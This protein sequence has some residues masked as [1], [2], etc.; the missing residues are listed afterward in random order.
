MKWTSNWNYP[1]PPF[2]MLANESSP[3]GERVDWSWHWTRVNF[4]IPHLTV[5]DGCR[6]ARWPW[7]R[8]FCSKG[9]VQKY[10]GPWKI[11]GREGPWRGPKCSKRAVGNFGC[12]TNIEHL[13]LWKTVYKVDNTYCTAVCATR[14]VWSLCK[15]FAHVCHSIQIFSLCRWGP[16]RC[17]VQKSCDENFLFE[18]FYKK[19]TQT[20]LSRAS[21][22]S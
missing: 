1:P 15:C 9:A 8:P 19:Q 2:Q 10:F 22:V 18:V 14:P 17:A 20:G 7:P 5:S 12:G 3:P 21:C 16:F 6:A 13:Y 4:S 11:W